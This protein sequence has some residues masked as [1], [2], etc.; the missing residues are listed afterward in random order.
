MPR[1]GSLVGGG[2]GGGQGGDVEGGCKREATPSRFA[3]AAQHNIAA[4]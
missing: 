2:R 3:R 4:T 1:D